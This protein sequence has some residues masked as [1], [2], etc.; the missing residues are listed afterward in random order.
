MNIYLNLSIIKNSSNSVDLRDNIRYLYPK[1]NTIMDGEFT[2]I[3]FSKNNIT[4]NGLYLY[5][6]LSI[7]SNNRN[8]YNK[9]EIYT[10]ILSR[11]SLNNQIISDLKQ[12]EKL[13]LNHYLEYTKCGKQ[14]ELIL[15]KQLI[16]NQLRVYHD[17]P[18][19]KKLNKYV[20]KISGIWE[21]NSKIGLTYKI[22]EL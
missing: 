2:K 7:D 19:S 6:P 17:K 11:T 20:I 10:R 9:N 18:Y 21:T 5:L 4:M 15:Q 3:L 16:T 1:K 22:M 14:P 13:I 8:N 12:L